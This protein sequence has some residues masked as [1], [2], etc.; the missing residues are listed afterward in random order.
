AALSNSGPVN[1]ASPVTVSFAN[2]SDPSSADTA[3]GFRYS[4]A[5][6]AANLAGSYTDAGS[7]ATALFTFD[8]N[9]TYTVYGRVFDKDDGFTD[10]QTTVTVNNVAPAA[11]VSGPA[12]GVRGQARTFTFTASDPSAVD[13]AASFTYAIDWGDGSSQTVSG[14]S[15]G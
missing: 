6:T 11:G 7:A 1:E 14:S 12:G 2:P 5:L 9:G 4:F 10:Y 15:A 13:Q 8:D 3:A